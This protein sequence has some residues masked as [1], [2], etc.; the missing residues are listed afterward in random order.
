MTDALKFNLKELIDDIYRTYLEIEKYMGIEV[1]TKLLPPATEAIISKFE[2]NRNIKFPPSY[3]KFLK[4]HNGWVG[5]LGD[6]T[7]IGV[8]GFNK[9]LTAI[10][11]VKKDFS[12]K[13]AAN[14]LSTNPVDIVKY[15]TERTKNAKTLAESNIYLPTKIIFGVGLYD[16]FLFFDDRTRTPDGE[17]EVIHLTPEGNIYKCGNFEQMLRDFCAIQ[18][19]QLQEHINYE[20]QQE[21]KKRSRKN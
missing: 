14:K 20:R 2:K 21:D 16:H 13:W 1:E 9:I 15:E 19:K 7:L 18:H 10:D 4:L 11:S 12:V 17:M 5:F 8:S 6:Y 3:K